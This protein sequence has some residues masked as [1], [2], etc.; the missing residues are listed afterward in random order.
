MLRKESPP[1]SHLTLSQAMR[2]A[3]NQALSDFATQGLLRERAV[4]LFS[5][6]GYQSSLTAEAGTVA[7][8]LERFD[9]RNNL[10]EK[11]HELFKAWQDVE[12]IFQI[13]DEEI[14]ELASS[15]QDLFGSAKFAEGRIES[16]LFIAVELEDR[17]YSR[18][19]LAEMTRA[20]NHLF[21]MPV[22]IL[23]RHGATLTLAVIHRRT[24]KRDD[25]RD[26]LE[27]VTLV[28]GI[29]TDA[30]HRAHIDIL[31]DLALPSLVNRGV[32]N[33]DQLHSAWE[34]TLDIEELN[35]RFY[36]ELF[37]WFQRAVEE[38]SFPDDG[39][40]AGN[41][42]RHVIRLITRL[43]FIWFLKEKGLVPEDL[44]DDK[45]AQTTIKH[46]TRDATDYYRAVLQNLF[47]ATLN[48]EIDKRA[49][50][51]KSSSTH[52]DFNKYRYR[53]LLANPDNF[54]A[55]LKSVP[56]VNGGLFDCLDDY[57]GVREG[58]RRIDAFTDNPTQGRDLDVPARLLLDRDEGLFPLFRS[59]KFTVEENTPL[60]REVALDPEL[61]GRVFENLLAAYNPETR[62]TAR[63]AT[64]SYYTPRHVVDYMVD[65]ALAPAL[66]GKTRPADGDIQFWHERLR[67]LLDY[68]NANADA[69]DLFDAGETQAVVRAIAGLRV[70]D[71]AVGSGAFPMGVLHKLT[72]A[73]RRLDPDNQ[74]WEAL[75]KERAGNRAASA[76]DTRNQQERDAELAEISDTFERY[77][78]SDFGRKLY[79]IQNSIFGVDVQ[80]V[81][82]QIAKLRF[83][84]SLVIEQEPNRTDR[85]HNYG[86]KPL[87]NLETRFVAA[88]TLIGLQLSEGKQLFEDVIQQKYQKIKVVREKYFLASNRTQKRRYISQE[89]KLRQE[90]EQELE[91]VLKDW[92]ATEE[93]ETDRKVALLPS[94]VSQKRFRNAE[95]ERLQ[96]GESRLTA[97]LAGF[98]RI[99]RW[100]PYDQ[101][102]HA[103]W[104]DPEYMFGIT[105]GFDV[106]IGNPPYIQLQNNGGELRKLYKPAGYD[107][108]SGAG[109]IYQLF[110]EKGCRLLRLTQGL[111]AYITSNSW[112]KAEY[113]KPLRRYLSERHTP[114]RLLE[115]GKDIFENTIVDTNILI[116]RH[117]H[118]EVTGKAVDM[119]RLPD[120]T[121]PPV[122]SVWG[123]LRT[124]GERPWS[125]LSAIEQTIMD[126][127]E[128]KGT[129][130]KEWDI[131][132]N[133]GIKTGYNSA[134][135]ID[136]ATKEALVGEDPRSAG[137][138]KPVLRGRDIQRYQAEWAGLWLIDTHNG[139]GDVPAVD[140]SDYPAV[141]THLDE[142]YPQ[143]KK[144]QDKGK[145]PYNLRSCAYYEDFAKEK[146]LWMDLTEEGRFAYDTHG[147]F[148]VNTAFMMS[149]PSIK[150]LCAL[151]NS[152]LIT[153]FMS[154]TALNSGM[155]VTRWINASVEAIPIPKI[156]DAQQRPF[157]R[158][159][160]GALKTKAAEPSMDTGERE[161][162]IDRL[163]YAL[164]G[165]TSE[166]SVAVVEGRTSVKSN[167]V[168]H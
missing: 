88:N 62:E 66:A 78:D 38:C 101:N 35:R 90:L 137:I 127:M 70:L 75:Q 10:T 144:R 39:A 107:T 17:R 119:D 106:V 52:R 45:F 139:Y 41:R 166:E 26:V 159:V 85:E 5:V 24:H 134:F 37:R 8:F 115:M 121:F 157:I 128:A 2:E 57:E 63:K 40:E 126:K 36:R 143:L 99:A 47:F 120:K 130:L 94:K 160:N 77:R 91:T 20:V 69:G 151:L 86:I 6:L 59:Y 46:H 150:Y 164:Y 65:E 156:S 79:L 116:V 55:K 61:L 161:T 140:I 43:L 14:A 49:F 109:D 92:R 67:Y 15:Q 155:G 4:A 105:G 168:R 149:G 3:L 148:C 167:P 33:F 56:F 72:L 102:A 117:S 125:T 111:L 152:K 31:A 51:K 131:A 104:F 138:I 165:L 44:F 13:T 142:F 29:R 154:N 18:G 83:F 123:E 25:N 76:F 48:T 81:A 146:L 80:P 95:R 133:Y 1:A 11:Q 118:S 34:R 132:I 23:F 110:Y 153:W 97:S 84:I 16:F 19:A 74:L 71:P 122:E 73:L 158:L 30:P 68:E 136:N 96:V 64:G 112:L 89:E 93:R 147:I 129:P 100:D 7:E 98:R 28:K 141:K 114:L 103:A 113:G 54:V 12:V 42:E 58:G 50:S 124:R 145:T 108:F 135:I 82:C 22:I 9:A 87:P 60:D 27:K 162:E 163:V 32:R 21:K 53:A